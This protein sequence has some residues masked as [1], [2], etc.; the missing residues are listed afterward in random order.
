MKARHVMFSVLFTANVTFSQAQGGAIF[1]PL[2]ALPG[3]GNESGAHGVS[4]NGFF[5]VGYD[6]SLSVE[7]RVAV[8]WEDV[9]GDGFFD[10]NDPD[11]VKNLAFDSDGSPWAVSHLGPRSLG[12]RAGRCGYELFPAQP[13]V[14]VD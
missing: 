4:A 6:T 13:G 7:D 5:V 2:P 9:N 3:G 1:R 10:P 8:R 14:S 11:E 12:R